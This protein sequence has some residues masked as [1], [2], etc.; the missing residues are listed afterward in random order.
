[1]QR[2]SGCRRG[3][4]RA[5]PTCAC[6]RCSCRPARGAAAWCRGPESVRST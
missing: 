4:V 3:R 2:G 1:V 6:T 5:W